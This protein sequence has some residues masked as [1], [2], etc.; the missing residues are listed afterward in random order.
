MTFINIGGAKMINV[1][2]TSA[3]RRVELIKCFKE[4]RDSL[5]LKG[6]I[7]A[8]DINNTA[9]ALYYAD[10]HYLI[11]KITDD[12]YI[13][14][15]I[16]LCNKEDIHLIIP[17]IDTELYKFAENKDFIETNT[18]AIVHVSNRNVM[19]ICRN[20]FNTQLFF[21]ENNIDAPRLISIDNLINKDYDFPLFIKPLNGS[22]SINTFKINN[23][24]ELQFFID[25]VPN[26][27]VQEFI[28][29][30]EYTVDAFT[31]FNSKIITIVPRLRIATRGGEV[32]KGIVK[33]D[34]EIIEQVKKVL[35]ALKP[36]GHITLQC[37]KTDDGIKFI[38]INPRFGGGAPIS[39]KA[40]A[41]SPKN[42]Y[43]LLLGEKLT[44]TENYKD[45]YLALR[46]D[47]AVFINL[48]KEMV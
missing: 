27:I 1:L 2:I 12:N 48:S 4:A 17:T 43:R 8:V 5:N 33:K 30:D 32:S 39:I 21:E 14:D 15:I 25:Y 7:V 3:G 23:E 26:P 34:K 31:D 9:P 10:K 28:E 24:K 16:E 44:Y 38:E 18:N 45:D 20:K 19:E 40:G 6:N 13:T 42:L 47:E 36:I 35:K 37:M 46:Y 11:S 22:S 41:D 29:G